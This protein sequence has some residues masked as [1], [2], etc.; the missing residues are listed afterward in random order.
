MSYCNYNNNNY[1]NKTSR[2]YLD[3]SAIMQTMQNYNYFLYY[4]FF[5]ALLF[6]MQSILL[7][8]MLILLCLVCSSHLNSSNRSFLDQLISIKI[9]GE[10]LIIIF[11][12]SCGL[13]LQYSL[14][15]VYQ[16]V[17]STKEHLQSLGSI[18]HGKTMTPSCPPNWGTINECEIKCDP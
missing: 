2:I 16:K 13:L 15:E 17:L 5:T 14:E 1:D 11:E 7:I 9:S 8:S 12:V 10:S 6:F 18:R 3:M 4:T